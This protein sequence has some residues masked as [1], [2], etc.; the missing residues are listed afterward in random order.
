M[1]LLLSV[2][3]FFAIIYAF[4]AINLKLGYRKML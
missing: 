4:A 3:G 1:R 2:L